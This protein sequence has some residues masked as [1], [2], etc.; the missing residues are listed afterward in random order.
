MNQRRGYFG[1]CK[2][3]PNSVRSTAKRRRMYVQIARNYFGES[4][5]RMSKERVITGT[6]ERGRKEGSSTRKPNS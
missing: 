1:N 2:E 6:D 3:T 4:H 5:G